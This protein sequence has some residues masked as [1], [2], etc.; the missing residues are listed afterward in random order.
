MNW[1]VNLGTETFD[2]SVES[3]SDNQFVV[4]VNG[5]PIEVDACFVE[6]GSLHLIHEGKTYEIDLQKTAEGHD[7]TFDGARYSAH[8]M[9]ERTRALHALGLGG[10]A[11]SGS[12][13]ISTSMPGK[14]VAILV[15]EGQAVETGSGIIVVEAMK[16]ENELRCARD[17]V[18]SRICVSVGDAVEGG[19]ALVHIDPLEEE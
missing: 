10:A 4:T 17:G 9:D 14:V 6:P 15:E 1:E 8:V 12:E 16:M 3:T 7:V 13:T 11:A 19:A 18:V 2:I 5:E